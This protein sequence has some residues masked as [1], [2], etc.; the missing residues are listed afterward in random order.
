MALGWGTMIIFGASHQLL[1]VLTESGLFSIT[2]GYLSFALAAAGIPLLVYGFYYFDLGWP[3]QWG[4]SAMVL[5]ILCYVINV[6][7]TI[8]KGKKR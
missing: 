2:L 7:G 1:P 5:S 8:T 4:G 3:A 6:A